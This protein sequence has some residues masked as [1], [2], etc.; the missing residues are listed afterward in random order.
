LLISTNAD[1]RVATKVVGGASY[2]LYICGG[3]VIRVLPTKYYYVI[4]T[5]AQ[6]VPHPCAALWRQVHVSMPNNHRF[7]LVMVVRC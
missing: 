1:L 5:P 3:P 7:T 6:A 2:I 4:H